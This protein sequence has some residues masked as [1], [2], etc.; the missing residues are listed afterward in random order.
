LGFFW[1][2]LTWM[3]TEWS[4]KRHMVRNA[5]DTVGRDTR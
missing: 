5:S 1:G 4:Y 3:A 2:L